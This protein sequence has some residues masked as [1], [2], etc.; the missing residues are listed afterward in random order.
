MSTIATTYKTFIQNITPIFGEG[1]ARS[2]ARI[3][4][5][6]EFEIHNVQRTQEF[7]LASQTRLQEIEARLLQ[8]EP[9]QYILG[10]ADFYGLKFKVD[11]RV[12]I[13]RQETEEL[14]A[15]LSEYLVYSPIYI[16]VLDIGTG[17][18][19]IP[20]AL[21]HDFPEATIHALDVSAEALEL[22]KE[23][24]GEREIHFH[25]LDILE[26]K[27]W[28][29]LEKFDYII[30]NPPYI[31]TEESELMPAWVRLFEPLIALFVEDKDP[32]LFYKRI[33]DFA[34]AHLY[35][36]G[37]LFFECNEFNAQEVADMLS[38]KGFDNVEIRKDL[39]GKNRMVKGDYYYF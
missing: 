18:G 14:V 33:A 36:E 8:N 7:P 34:L 6:D 37:Q 25:Q 12:L 2:I 21:K 11:K 17:S 27:E 29:T 3:V 32:L 1:E 22:A 39:N 24:A 16:N 23:N 28:Q 13:P 9:I 38:Q 35:P 5:E 19:C 26:E 31:P 30:S 20:I 4:F 10:Q 15:W